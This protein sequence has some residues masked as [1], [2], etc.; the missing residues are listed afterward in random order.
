MVV[1]ADLCLLSSDDFDENRISENDES[2]GFSLDFNVDM[3]PHEEEEEDTEEEEE[4]KEE[5]YALH[6]N[7]FTSPL[8]ISQTNTGELGC[9]VW[10][11]ALAL[12]EY[13]SVS[14]SLSFPVLNKAVL[15][16]GCGVGLGGFVAASLGA[17][18]VCLAIVG[19]TRWRT[20]RRRWRDGMRW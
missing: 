7:N 14:S 12:C 15:E 13:L 17:K 2:G 10:N 16:V 5:L 3:R 6:L 8:F 9:R 18:T 1:G 20:S 11:C 19:K 4:E